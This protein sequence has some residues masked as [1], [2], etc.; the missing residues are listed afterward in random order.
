MRLL[1]ANIFLRALVRSDADQEHV[2]AASCAALFERLA[3]G[4][5]EATTLEVIIATV[6]Y[7]LRSPRQYG[8]APS[9]VAARLRPLLLVR[10]LKL[11]Y[12]R[13]VL[14]ALDLW[15]AWP[16]LDFDDALLVAHA[17]RL[18]GA[19]ILSLNRAFDTIPDVV[20]MEP[21]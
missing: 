2:K 4:G 10:G 16:R 18:G 5:E 13:T 19:E 17:E 20:R 12:K 21:G 8:L 1:D 9:E 3:S 14:R 6:C 7:V 15:S 11:P